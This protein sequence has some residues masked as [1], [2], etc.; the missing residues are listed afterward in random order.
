MWLWL[1]VLGAGWPAVVAF[2]PLGVTTDPSTLAELVGESLFVAL[3]LGTS[4]GLAL[5][6]RGSWFLAGT[7]QARGVAAQW[8]V[9]ASAPVP[10][11]AAALLPAALLPH[12]AGG[13][14]ASL[15]LRFVLS[16]VH[17]AA[18][19]CVLA[20]LPLPG[21]HRWLALPVL[22][23]LAPALL[24]PDGP[25]PDHLLAVVA[26]GAPLQLASESGSALWVAALGPIIGL[27]VL[28]AALPHA[29]PGR[30]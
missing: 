7:G 14:D 13:L 23:W 21:R 30:P 28:A 5:L 25:A 1:L 9:L 3:L 12:D 24:G 10:F 8:A 17:V 19:A 4:V 18:I 6:G 22:V 16:A 11:V 29:A 2:A 20:R 15:A 27:A 26:A